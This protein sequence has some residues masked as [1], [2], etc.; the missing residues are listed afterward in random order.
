[1]IG[2]LTRIRGNS[3]PGVILPRM[4]SASTPENLGPSREGDDGIGLFRGFAFALVPSIAIWA[5]L[6]AAANWAFF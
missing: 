6:I 2:A 3:G 5:M 1:M 4:D